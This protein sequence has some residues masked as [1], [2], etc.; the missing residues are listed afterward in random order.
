MSIEEFIDYVDRVIN[1][2]EVV[3]YDIISSYIINLNWEYLI[4]VLNGCG[5]FSCGQ[6]LHIEMRYLYD[7]LYEY[8]SHSH[9]AIPWLEIHDHASQVVNSFKVSKL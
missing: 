9:E 7:V 5:E 2:Y 8:I 6:V 4:D 1:V 3:D